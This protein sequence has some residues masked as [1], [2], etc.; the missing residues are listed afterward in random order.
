M[1]RWEKLYAIEPTCITKESRRTASRPV[2]K[3]GC[4]LTKL[5]KATHGS[6]RTC[7]KGRSACWKWWI[8]TLQD[9]R[10]QALSIASSQLFM[11]IS[12]LKLVRR[13]PD[14]STLALTVDEGERLDFDEV[15]LP[16]DSWETELGEDEY[17]VERIADVRSGWRTRYGRV[18]RE[19]LV[20]WK[21]YA[22]PS[23]VDEADLNCGALLQEFERKRVNRSRFG[24]MQ[25]HEA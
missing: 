9:W 14:R 24:V 6:S 18:H 21:G 25:S 23:W 5:K 19:F 11:F 13:F 4:I 12:K 17:E 7:G 16:E 8:D 10:P 1:R 15:L 3:F 20:Y 22:E 2:R